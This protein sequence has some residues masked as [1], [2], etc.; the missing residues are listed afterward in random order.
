MKMFVLAFLILSLSALV[1]AQLSTTFYLSTCPNVSKI[2]RRE[3]LK[4]FQNE[5][6]IAASLLRLHFHD[7]FVN[8]CDGSILL[9]GSSGEKFAFPNINSV[10]GFEVV[11]AIKNALESVCSG[12]VSCADILAIAARHSVEFSGGPLWR[13]FLGRRDGTVANQTGANNNLPSPFETLDQIIAKFDVQ[14]LNVTDVVSL[15]G[16]HTIG[17]AQ[18]STFS[19]RLYNFSGSGAPDPTIASDLLPVLQNLCPQGGNA[20]VLSPLDPNTTS[21]FDN[22]YY[23]NLRN[24]KGILGSDQ[25]LFSAASAATTTKPIVETYSTST[26]A[27]F[28]NF[29]VSMIK[30]GNISPLTGSAGQ[31]RANCRVVN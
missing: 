1:K 10:R 28:K 31:I 15:S 11:D 14:G 25:V 12:V 4:A 5:T 13:V 8:G 17:F 20:S 7:C 30:M 22:Q 3:V 21:N 26:T 24:G 16:A 23:N 9:D 6:R 27:F 29:A 18:C 2:V 19:P